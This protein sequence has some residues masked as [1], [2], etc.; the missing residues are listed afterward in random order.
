MCYKISYLSSLRQLKL[1]NL[2]T[3]ERKIWKETQEVNKK[4][5]LMKQL[6]NKIDLYVIVVVIVT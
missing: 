2:I 3:E 1:K 6:G 5:N 4:Q